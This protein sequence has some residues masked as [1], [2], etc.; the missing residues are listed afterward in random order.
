MRYMIFVSHGTYAPGLC[1]ALGMIGG[2]GREDIL[3]TSLL[4]G[5]ALDTYGANLEELTASITPEDEVILMGDL[6]GGSPLTKAGEILS[7]KGLLKRM[8]VIG[9]MNLPMAIT[10]A[11]LDPSMP[12]QDA[13]DELIRA[14]KEEVKQVILDTGDADDDDI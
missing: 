5:M 8:A 3:C 13:A 1:N 11:F 2:T 7:A 14:S 4:D 6:A 10:A 12:L 9:G